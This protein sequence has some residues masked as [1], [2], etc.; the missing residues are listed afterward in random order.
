MSGTKDKNVDNKAQ[1][2]RKEASMASDFYVLF[3]RNHNS[4]A[5]AGLATTEVVSFPSLA[6]AEQYAA[7]IRRRTGFTNVRVISG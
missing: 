4:G 6:S 3:T 1:S 7:G 2:A 5:L